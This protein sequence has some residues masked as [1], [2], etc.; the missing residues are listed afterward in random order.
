[1]FILTEYETNGK[2]VPR[3]INLQQVVSLGAAEGPRRDEGYLTV[4]FMPNGYAMYSKLTPEEI[5][6]KTIA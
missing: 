6:A 4:L 1:M 3:Y 5:I 2:V